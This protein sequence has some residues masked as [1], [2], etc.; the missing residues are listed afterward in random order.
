MALLELARLFSKLYAN[1]RTQPKM[2]LLFL[3]SGA[4]KFNYLG[5]KKW[6]EEHLDS[7]ESNLLSES[8][9]TVCLDSLSDSENT[10]GLFMHVSKPPKE[11]TSAAIFF[12]DLQQV[13]ANILDYNLNVSLV[14]KKINLADETLSWEHERFS[15]RRLPAFTL[16]SLSNSKT[17]GRKTI[18]DVYNE[19]LIKPLMKNIEIISEA[20]A[21]HLYGNIE[22]VLFNSELQISEP[23]IK[24]LLLHLSNES[25][26][27]TL[28][29]SSQ[30]SGSSN[31]MPQLLSTL[32]HI[33]RKFVSE[34]D[35][36]HVKLDSKDPEVVFYEPSIAT[37]N[38]YKYVVI[39]FNNL[40][41]I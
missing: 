21:R 34:V 27:Q 12:N 28:L 36:Q 39:V 1:P 23:F 31:E 11:G 16:S 8:L 4:G 15:I 30:R 14:H 3:L 18:T 20:T 35:V 2:N 26:A 5:T 19:N 25:R 38:I 33:M 37:L 40:F 22:M 24:S 29:L 7:S 17:S 32:E 6:I 13:A 41:I 9:F 10:N